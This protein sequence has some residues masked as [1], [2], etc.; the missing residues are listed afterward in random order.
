[1]VAVSVLQKEVLQALNRTLLPWLSGEATPRIALAQV[2][3]VVSASIAVSFK[4]SPAL[5]KP[6]RK[7]QPVHSWAKQALNSI[8]IPT[9]IFVFEGE[10]D[11]R[12]GTTAEQIAA[13]PT[14]VKH[15]GQYTIAMPRVTCLLV[16]PGTPISDAT[17]PHWERPHLEKAHSQIFWL[18]ILPEAAMCHICRTHGD[19]HTSGST[20]LITDNQ[21]MI[22]T[23]LLF[24]EMDSRQRH[25][26]GV[27]KNLLFTML[28]RVE[29]NLASKAPTLASDYLAAGASSLGSHLLGSPNAL[30]LERACRFVH[31]NLGHPLTPTMIA[32]NAYVSLAQLKRIF[33]SEL[34]TSVMQYVTRCRMDAARLLLQSTAMPINEIASHVGYSN[35]SHFS[36]GFAREVGR[37]PRAFRNGVLSSPEVPTHIK[38]QTQ[39]NEKDGS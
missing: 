21:L 24:E 4:P 17:R 37:S 31:G 23:E 32:S 5:K 7:A 11:F 13:N 28:M 26:E 33:R 6:G 1:M 36:S 8:N 35:L 14:L 18:R 38:P 29:R 22:L 34:N 15:C 19:K 10:A 9:L 2:P 30:A 3:P 16:P 25:F 12:I 39:S 27:A 20:L